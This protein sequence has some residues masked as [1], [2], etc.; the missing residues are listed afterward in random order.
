MEKKQKIK[1][2]IEEIWENDIMTNFSA[3]WDYKFHCPKRKSIH[4]ESSQEN[5]S[6]RRSRFWKLNVSNCFKKRK[7]A[8]DKTDITM[9][10]STMDY[11]FNAE[12]AANTQGYTSKGFFLD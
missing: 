5:Q 12:Y 11:N 4:Y 1:E 8:L 9:F 6:A 3:H 2:D 10:A 7:P